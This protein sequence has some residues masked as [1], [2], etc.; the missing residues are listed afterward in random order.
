MTVSKGQGDLLH[1]GTPPLQQGLRLTHFDL[2][3][4][5]PGRQSSS[6]DKEPLQAHRGEAEIVRQCRHRRA[7]IQVAQHPGLGE[8]E[9]LGRPRCS[10]V[11]HP[12]RRALASSFKDLLEGTK[13]RGGIAI[14]MLDFPTRA[15]MQFLKA[16]QGGFVHTPDPA[17]RL[18]GGTQKNRRLLPNP[19]QQHTRASRAVLPPVAHIRPGNDEA[20]RNQGPRARTSKE[21]RTPREHKHG[22]PAMMQPARDGVLS[23]PPS[24]PCEVKQPARRL[25]GRKPVRGTG[26]GKNQFASR[27]HRNS[28]LYHL[29][30]FAISSLLASGRAGW[31]DM[32]Q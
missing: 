19:H 16:R 22:R 5:T 3:E 4:R 28:I 12:S 32:R 23:I 9:L 26:R 29:S 7:H 25:S 1:R 6:F 8:V 31:N 10:I 30:V 18:A 13:H 2:K 14:G 15:L 21:N 24:A 17:R 27:P 20:P 11:P